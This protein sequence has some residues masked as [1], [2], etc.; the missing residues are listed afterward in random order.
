MKIMEVLNMKIINIEHSFED[1]DLDLEM[2]N[3][4]WMHSYDELYF[5][6]IIDDTYKSK[7]SSKLE[8]KSFIECRIFNKNCEYRVTSEDSE[9]IIINKATQDEKPCLKKYQR[10]ECKFENSK[11]YVNLNIIESLETDE[12]GQ[13]YISDK[14]MMGVDEV[15]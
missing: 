15:D 3:Y 14:Y 2:P 10:V 13:S 7:I 4:F 12:D 5:E 9:L 8:S 6:K 1:I 11:K